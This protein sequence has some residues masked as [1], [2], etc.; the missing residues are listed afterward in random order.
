[1]SFLDTSVDGKYTVIEALL[2]F[3]ANWYKKIPDGSIQEEIVTKLNTKGRMI[4]TIFFLLMLNFCGNLG[5]HGGGS[6]NL[7]SRIIGG[8]IAPNRKFF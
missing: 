2:C 7:E 1:M 4:V 3:N 5:H 8:Q 6:G